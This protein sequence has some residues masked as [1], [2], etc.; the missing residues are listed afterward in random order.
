VI[1]FTRELA[2]ALGI[3]S[4]NHN[5]RERRHRLD[6]SEVGSEER[7]TLLRENWYYDGSLQGRVAI[8]IDD[9]LVTGSSM[10]VATDVLT[11]AGAEVIPIALIR[12]SDETQEMEKLIRRYF[13]ERYDT[14]LQSINIYGSLRR[15][16]EQLA[17]HPLP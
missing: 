9:V 15:Q 3:E 17:A 7:S 5:F 6:V 12:L 13:A 11:R 4:V 10:T 16:I 8:L 1:R 14:L 2:N